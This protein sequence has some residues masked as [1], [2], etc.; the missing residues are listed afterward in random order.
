MLLSFNK[1]SISA[2]T[3]PV[4]HSVEETLYE[5]TGIFHLNFILNCSVCHRSFIGFCVIQNHV[6]VSSENKERKCLKKYA[7]EP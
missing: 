3:V 6:I 2:V 1:C 5:K 4:Y 7:R